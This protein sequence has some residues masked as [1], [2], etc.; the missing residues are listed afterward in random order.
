MVL[1]PRKIDQTFPVQFERRHL[2]AD[3]LYRVRCGFSDRLPHFFKDGLNLL[4]KG[5]DVFVDRSQFIL[6]LSIR[7]HLLRRVAHPRVSGRP[8]ASVPMFEGT[9]TLTSI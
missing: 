2:I 4:W 7:F 9:V 1:V 3:G 5:L 8:V 6:L